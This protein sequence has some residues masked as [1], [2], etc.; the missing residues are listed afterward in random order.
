MPSRF[1]RRARRVQIVPGRSRIVRAA[2]CPSPRPQSHSA[3]L[4][5]ALGFP[6]PPGVKQPIGWTWC[7]D[8][9]IWCR[10]ACLP[11][12]IQALILEGRAGDEL[13]EVYPWTVETLEP[14]QSLCCTACGAV[15][16]RE[17]PIPDTEDES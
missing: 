2:A 10:P 16:Y 4:H 5:D 3:A 8:G 7:P 13:G 14:G 9:R 6:P 17:P 15:I 12:E 1:P 11:G